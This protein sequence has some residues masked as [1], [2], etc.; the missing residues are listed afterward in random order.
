MLRRIFIRRK[1]ELMQKI[2]RFAHAICG[3]VMLYLITMLDVI[4]IGSASTDFCSQIDKYPEW[5]SKGIV[6]DL[7]IRGGGSSANTMV[8]CKKLGLNTGF[9][10]VCSDDHFG[11]LIVS[12]LEQEKIDI[13]HLIIEKESTSQVAFCFSELTSGKRTIFRHRGT[14]SKLTEN[15]L[16]IDYI[17]S[18]RMLHFDLRH[19]KACLKAAEM[20]KKSNIKIYVDAGGEI[21]ENHDLLHQADYLFF[22][23]DRAEDLTGETDPVKM[24]M[25]LSTFK[26]EIMGITLGQQGCII[27]QKGNVRIFPAYQQDSIVD[28]TGAGDAFNGGMIYAILN[29]LGISESVNFASAVA[30]LSCTK[31]SARDGLPTLSEVRKFLNE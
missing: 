19:Y 6:D 20:V 28:S 14:V 3:L 7:I 12:S 25:A 15:D 29:N 13:S 16:K 22:S 1:L 2:S 26:N 18:A 8:A 21:T 23:K 9:I 27:Q 4:G 10:S 17:Q 24:I 11:K 31:L 30:A 5:D